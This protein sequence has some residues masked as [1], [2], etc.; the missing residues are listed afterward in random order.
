M[1]VCFFSQ[2]WER[3]LQNQEGPVEQIQATYSHLATS[4]PQ[5]DAKMHF[6]NEKWDQMITHGNT[7]AER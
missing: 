4:S 2:D 1:C 5:A 6:V 7:Y 3:A